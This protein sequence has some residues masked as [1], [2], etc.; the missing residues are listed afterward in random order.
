MC[1]L[2]V[3]TLILVHKSFLL[4]QW[5]ERIR[6]FAPTATIGQIQGSKID[7]EGK[8]VVIGMLQSLSMKDYDSTILK[9]FGLVIIDEV[10]HIGAEVFCR[11]LPKISSR[12]MLGLSATPNRKDGL[13]K[14]I[15]WY[16]GPMAYK[17]DRLGAQTVVVKKIVTTFD[18]EDYN[19]VHTNYRG[20]PMIPKMINNIVE[21]LPR[22][23]LILSEIEQYI[24]EEPRQIMV[25]S[26][27]IAHLTALKIALDAKNLVISRQQ[28]SRAMVTGFYTGKQKA[29]ELVV[30]E[31]A[32][33]IFSTYSMTREGLDIPTLNTLIIATPTSDVVQT[34]GRILRKTHD[35][36]P[37][38]IDIVDNFGPFANQATKRSAFYRKSEYAI[39]TL[40][41][42]EALNKPIAALLR[43][44]VIK[45]PKGKV[46]IIDDDDDDN[47]EDDK[48]DK[49]DN[50]NTDKKK[51]NTEKPVF[52]FEDD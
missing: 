48:N 17:L 20:T 39:A 12:Y 51:V 3:K 4:T 43:A 28:T 25:I 34:C 40:K 44:A 7:V 9:S 5:V 37:L 29:K 38:V 16:I 52:A 30:S 42:G 45:K 49:N 41:D 1:Q 13:T 19:E 18:D 50:D 22:N 2:K 46:L 11:A 10:H 33:V 6:Q 47:D 8:D 14:V 23:Q 24:A 36:S 27:R 32:D 21:Y 31:R 15:N 35:I 26:D